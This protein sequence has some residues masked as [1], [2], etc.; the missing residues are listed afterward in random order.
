MNFS[1]CYSLISNLKIQGVLGHHLRTD[2]KDVDFG[3]GELFVMLAFGC[4]VWVP[5]LRSVLL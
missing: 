4:F 2:L 5:I 3:E 1:K